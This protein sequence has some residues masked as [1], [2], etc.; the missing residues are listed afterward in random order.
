[1]YCLVSLLHQRI[2]I[3]AELF[4][5]NLNNL[6]DERI[7]TLTYMALGIAHTLGITKTPLPVLRKLDKDKKP[8]EDIRKGGKG[9]THG[10]RLHSKE[11]QRAYLGL[12]YVLSM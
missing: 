11:E 10:M 3:L 2:D 1:M 7:T 6:C 9:D 4:R 5:A 12:Y 8:A